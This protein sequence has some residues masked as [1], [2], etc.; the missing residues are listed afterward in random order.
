MSTKSPFSPRRRNDLPTIIVAVVLLLGVGL[1]W[2]FLSH[3]ARKEHDRIVAEVPAFP[4]RGQPVPERP[5]PMPVAR[6]MPAPP[7]I[8][9]VAAPD[10]GPRPTPLNVSTAMKQF[11]LNSDP[12][13]VVGVIHV[14]SLLNAPLLERLDKCF[15]KAD[16]QANASDGGID[17]TRDVDQLAFSDSGEML[18][19]FFD[20]EGAKTLTRCRDASATPREYRGFK[21]FD[22]SNGAVAFQPSLA[23][24]APHGDIEAMIDQALSVPPAGATA[25]DVYG[26]IYMH[27][28]LEHAREPG[29]PVAQDAL[30]KLMNA[31]LEQT[32]NVTLRANIWD[33]VALSMDAVPTDGQSAEDLAATANAALA[34]AKTSVDPENI[35]LTAYTDLAKVQA[36]DGR[37]QVNVALPTDQLVEEMNSFCDR[38][39]KSAEERAAR[40]KEAKETDEAADEGDEQPDP[41]EAPAPPQAGEHEGH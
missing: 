10:A 39:R 16:L 7:A 21:V 20:E 24:R 9:A 3:G 22:C 13:S 5:R 41:D 8:V 29:S 12:Q 17:F 40:M 37:L 27:S 25:D 36:Q 2:M 28:G 15:P 11:V 23:M 34:L 31:A 6:P 32:S 4:S 35:R 33:S 19:G 30:G 38:K 14:N 18:S 26:D 1:W